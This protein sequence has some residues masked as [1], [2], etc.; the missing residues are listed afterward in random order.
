ML[1][2]LKYSPHLWLNLSRRENECKKTKCMSRISVAINSS[3][4][5]RIHTHTHNNNDKSNSRVES[6]KL[7]TFYNVGDVVVVVVFALNITN[8]GELRTLLKVNLL[9][10][11][12]E[13]EIKVRGGRQPQMHASTFIIVWIRLVEHLLRQPFFR[14]CVA[15]ISIKPHTLLFSYWKWY[16]V[17]EMQFRPFFVETHMILAKRE[18]FH[19]FR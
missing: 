4:L 5:H 8:S 19:R 14:S 17:F 16:I 7:I 3:S 10:T 9:R 15:C 1:C 11:G 12:G 6:I 2:T 18:N 13:R